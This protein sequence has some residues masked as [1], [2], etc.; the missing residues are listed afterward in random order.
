[1]VVTKEI[2]IAEN[3]A[4]KRKEKGITQEE[5]ASFIGVSK[6]SVSK[7]ETGNSFP[8][9]NFLPQLAAYFNISL[10][11]LMA[12][13]PQMS[14]ADIRTLYT[15][16]ISEFA[17][18][19]LNEVVEHCHV[20]VKKY[21]ACAPLLYQIAVLLL[22]NAPSAEDELQK[23][24]IMA[25]AKVLLVRVRELSENIELSRLALQS[26]AMYEMMCDNPQNIVALLENECRLD[27][28]PSIGTLLS[29][30]HQMLGHH[31]EANIIS[32]GSVFDAV[33]SLFY[34]ITSYLSICSDDVEKFEATYQRILVLEENF[35]VKS[36]FPLAVLSFYMTAA[37][38]YLNF[39]DTEK[40]LSMLESYTLLVSDPIFSLGI[41]DDHFFSL[42]K[43]AR[44]K[45]MS[46]GLIMPVLPRDEQAM[47]R[48]IVHAVTENPVFFVLSD[49][50]RYKR[51]VDKLNALL[52]N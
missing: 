19:P 20:I 26:E 22:N 43:E 7:W 11:E 15:K 52:Q 42:I 25:E 40:T 9:V 4:R 33:I 8:D 14:D 32:Q 27:P 13:E 17:E 49:L 12:Y 23:S 41:K 5:L 38:G 10:D 29:H 35:K 50:S 30:A 51:I 16:L 39:E 18:K 2:R 21:Y 45:Q 44:K 36:L 46:G 48:E 34:E 31:L 47:K 28:Q 1:M 6:A 3:I 37:Q 24:T